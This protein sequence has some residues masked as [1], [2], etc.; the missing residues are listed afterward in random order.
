[1]SPSRCAF[2]RANLRARRTCLGLFPGFAFRRLFI[3]APLLH[4]P[5]YAFA[6]HFLFQNTEGLVDIV[7]AHKNPQLLFLYLGEQHGRRKQFDLTF[8][9]AL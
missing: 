3:G 5:K 2:L 4:F 8:G 6:L 9:A 1:M 7:V